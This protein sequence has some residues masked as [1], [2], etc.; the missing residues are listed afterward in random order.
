M[1]NRILACLFALSAALYSLG[2]YAQ[3][4]LYIA[5]D[6][7]V[8]VYDENTWSLVQTI[9]LP[10]VHGVR[11]IDISSGGDSALYIS[12]EDD[13]TQPGWVLKYDLVNKR[14]VWNKSFPNG[15]DQFSLSRDGT[16]LYMPA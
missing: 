14:V 15:I 7:V 11:G 9:H 16:K 12:Y 8:Y 13:L 2:A 1:R 5:Q 3:G 6:R 10:Q 4:M